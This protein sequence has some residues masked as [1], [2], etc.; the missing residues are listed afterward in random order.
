MLDGEVIFFIIYQMYLLKIFF[1]YT[2]KVMVR[3]LK[4]DA[5]KLS[6]KIHIFPSN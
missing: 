3:L 6:S 1:P 5:N 2:E 4:K